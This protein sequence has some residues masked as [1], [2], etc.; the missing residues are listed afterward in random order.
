MRIRLASPSASKLFGVAGSL[1]ANRVLVRDP[2]APVSMPAFSASFD[3][4]GL[5]GGA[6]AQVFEFHSHPGHPSSLGSTMV[7]FFKTKVQLRAGKPRRLTGWI[8]RV[9]ELSGVPWR[10]RVGSEYHLNGPQVSHLVPDSGCMLLCF[11]P[12]VGGEVE[13]GL[14]F[15]ASA[16]PVLPGGSF[17]YEPR[18]VWVLE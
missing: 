16:F 2:L 4:V 7:D 18:S 14:Q 5:G 13:L 12:S 17:V 6:V 8:R 15:P 11:T 10:I 3:E 9:A 1:Q